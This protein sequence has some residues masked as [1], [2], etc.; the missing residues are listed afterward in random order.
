L[1]K[2]QFRQVIDNLLSNAV[3]IISPHKWEIYV[4][5]ISE[6]WTITIEIED[7]GIWFTDLDIKKI[8]DKYSTGK[9]S[10][11]GLWMGLYLCKT[12]VELHW[13]NIQAAFGK[14]LW[15]AKII[16]KIPHI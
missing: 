5:T 6:K 13:G 9:W 11:V 15:W 8:F 1:D 10:S 4:S 16:I 14:R 3:K 7:N 12:I 2:V